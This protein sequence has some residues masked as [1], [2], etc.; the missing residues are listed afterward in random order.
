MT[1]RLASLFSGIG[2]LDL[3]FKRAGFKI[4]FANDNWKGCKETYELNHGLMLNQ[5][6]IVDVDSS[7]IPHVDGFIGG[8]PCQSWSLAGAMRGIDDSRG[9]LLYEYL[10]LID[11]KKPKFFL[12]ENVPGMICKKHVNDF[13]EFVETLK[14][15]G[16]N[17]TYEVLNASDYGVAQ[18]RKRVFLVGIRSNIHKQ[19][20]FP[21]KQPHKIT[22]RECIGDLPEA[23]PTKNKA[24]SINDLNFPNHEYMTG[25]FSS[26]YMSRNRVRKWD[27]QSFTIQ[28]GGR[29]IPCHPQASVMIKV[30][31]DKR[32]FDPNTP[33]PYRRLSVRECARIQSFPDSFN[34]IYDNINDGYKMIGNAVPVNLAYHLARSFNNLFSKKRVHKNSLENYGLKN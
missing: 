20:I 15:V 12:M 5:K 23:I 19:F 31:K 16:Y 30:S 21:T 1:I 11:Q 33:K 29:H 28:A 7:E 2:G 3:G 4:V 6:S 25:S 13:N 26:I 9:K 8:P 22:L 18:D 17:L 34:F 14:E 32:I 24:N 10:R 27:E